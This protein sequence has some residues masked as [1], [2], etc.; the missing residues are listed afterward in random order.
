MKIVVTSIS[1][2]KSKTYLIEVCDGTTIIH[3]EEVKGIKDRDAVDFKFTEIPSIPVLEI[4]EADLF[5]DENSDFVYERILQTVEEGLR[6]KRTEIRLFELNG[7]G[8]YVTSNRPDWKVG[9][10]QALDYFVLT[11]QYDKC[12]TAR[13][14]LQKL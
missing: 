12:I 9:V 2:N 7:T 1:K 11:E 3:S 8:V 5:F 10:Q 6:S 13:Q 4:E 14:L